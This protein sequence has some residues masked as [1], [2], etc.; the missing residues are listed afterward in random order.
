MADGIGKSD[1]EL[2]AENERLRA[3]VERLKSSARGTRHSRLRGVTMWILVVLTSLSLVATIVGV[4]TQRTLASEDR[5]VALVAPLASDPVIQE[6]LASRLTE[7]VF[8]ALEVEDRVRAALSSISEV[9]EAAQFLVGPLVAGFE[10]LVRD[11]VEG[12]LA[13]DRFMQLWIGIN[14]AAHP[15]VQALLNGDY[16][17]LPNVEITG[18]EVRLLLVPVVAEIL[19]SL[20]EGGLT[21]LGINATI[22]EIP[23]S[24]DPAD[25]I[26]QLG[27]ALGVTLPDDFGQVTVL[28]GD[29]LSTYQDAVRGVKRIIGGLFVLTLIL[30]VLTIVVAVDRRRAII[31]LG[32]AIALGLFLGGVV[33]RRIERDVIDTI[34]AP[35][36]RAAAQDVYG[37]VVAG[38]RGV[39][40]WV[41][42]VALVAVLAAYLSGRPAW[43]QRMAAAVERAIES[44]P[45][46]S[47]LEVWVAGH[48]EPVRIA[49]IGV[50]VLVLF[51]TGIDWVPLAVVALAL[52]LVLWGVAIA[53]QRTRPSGA[54]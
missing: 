37:A 52:G 53:E 27:S 36:A 30:L 1:A 22:P 33:L 34:E 6:A 13:S 20:A 39:G 40:L 17:E 48:T 5:Y 24:V 25:A 19:R 49:A 46:G 38:L 50:A 4:W 45:G 15:K 26:Q 10:D 23:P 14:R 12:F 7:E 44:K 18:G 35:G 32:I 47:N 54:T 41:F 31:A 28:T 11:R 16:D 43:F 3:E 21:A 42:V 2:D 29:Q 8:V 51:V 9:P